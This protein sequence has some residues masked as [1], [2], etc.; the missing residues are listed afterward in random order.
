MPPE[1]REFVTLWVA[2]NALYGGE[3]DQRERARAMNTVRRYIS[4]TDAKHLLKRHAASIARI[5]GVPPGDMR[6]DSWD[7]RFRAASERCAQLVRG[8][9]EAPRGRLAGVA[10]MLYQV[11]C[12]VVHGAKDPDER[13][14]RMLVR[15]S[16][17]I[18]RD[19]VPT[20]ERAM[21]RL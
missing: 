3:L 8:R 19:L 6:L 17:S 1:W 16:L 13:R 12:D 4:A 9:H 10:G 14:D 21:S 20:L 7:P 15:E 2:Y 11:R 18:L 5:I